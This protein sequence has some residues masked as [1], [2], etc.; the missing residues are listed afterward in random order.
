[1]PDNNCNE[2]SEQQSLDCDY[3]KNVIIGG[4]VDYKVPRSERGAVVGCILVLLTG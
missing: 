1:M 2:T 4:R 3:L